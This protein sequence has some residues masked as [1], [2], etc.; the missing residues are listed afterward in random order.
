MGASRTKAARNFS[1]QQSAQNNL[2][3]R[4]KNTQ[5]IGERDAFETGSGHLKSFCS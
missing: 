5:R 2:H 3:Y 1:R 4:I